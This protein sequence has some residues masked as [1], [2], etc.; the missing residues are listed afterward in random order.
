MT[1]STNPK[2]AICRNLYENTGLTHGEDQYT[3]FF[4]YSTQTD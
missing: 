4:V 1:I 3:D 2:P